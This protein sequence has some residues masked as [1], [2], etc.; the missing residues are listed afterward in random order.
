MVSSLKAIFSLY[1]YQNTELEL[2]LPLSIQLTII[3]GISKTEYM[4]SNFVCCMEK[5]F[6]VFLNNN[7]GLKENN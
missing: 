1:L 3:K 7:F 5:R 4:Q 6:P 2:R